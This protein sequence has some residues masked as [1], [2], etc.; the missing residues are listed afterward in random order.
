MD[1]ED[2]RHQDTPTRQAADLRPRAGP[3]PHLQAA[4]QGWGVVASRSRHR[5]DQWRR[6]PRKQS[7]SGTCSLPFG[8]D[9]AGRGYQEKDSRHAPETFGHQKGWPEDQERWLSKKREAQA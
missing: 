5:S 1:R 7:R 6:A 2:A 3:V 8:K 9:K 4:D